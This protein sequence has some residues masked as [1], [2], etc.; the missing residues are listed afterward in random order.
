MELALK[1]A[2]L[3]KLTM[4]AFDETSCRRGHNYLTF[5]ADAEAHKVVFVSEGRD[6][7]TISVFAQF[8]GEYNREAKQIACVARQEDMAGSKLCA[9]SSTL[10]PET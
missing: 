4:L 10:S 3:S 9:P 7:K 1:K 5:A 2:D 8:L 6:A